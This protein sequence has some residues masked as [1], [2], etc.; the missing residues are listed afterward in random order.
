[1]LP[2][3]ICCILFYINQ[4]HAKLRKIF[5]LYKNIGNILIKIFILQRKT[6]FFE[7]H[8]LRP[9]KIRAKNL[10]FFATFLHFLCNVHTISKLNRFSTIDENTALRRPRREAPL[11]YIKNLLYL[12]NPFQH[13]DHERTH[14]NPSQTDGDRKRVRLVVCATG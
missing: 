9:L 2:Y 3:K 14:I 10:H 7:N 13:Y 6:P 5:H 11:A 1:M 12:C 4:K 8:P